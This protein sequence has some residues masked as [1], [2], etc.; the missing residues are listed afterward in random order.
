MVCTQ[1]S[2]KNGNPAVQRFNKKSWVLSIQAPIQAQTFKDSM[3]KKTK[4]KTPQELF[5]QFTLDV[6]FWQEKLNLRNWDIDVKAKH[7][8]NEHANVWMDVVARNATVTF[9]LDVHPD[10]NTSET[11]CHEL[12]HVLFY[13]LQFLVLSKQNLNHEIVVSEEH[14]IIKLLVP[15]LLEL[16]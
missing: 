5:K 6:R 3:A 15:M 1:L 16:E 4:Q 12:L 14:S 8:E 7:L 13:S 9:N 10:L 11:A 2:G